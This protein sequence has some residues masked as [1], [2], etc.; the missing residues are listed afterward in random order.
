[1]ELTVVGS[2]Y[3]GSAAAL[4]QATERSEFR[5]SDFDLMNQQLKQ[6]QIVSGGRNLFD[7]AKM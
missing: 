2:G 6:N 7:V 1:M 3:V 4:I 5:T